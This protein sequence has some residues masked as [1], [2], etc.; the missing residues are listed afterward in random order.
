MSTVVVKRPA[1]R[2]APEIPE[3]EL[4]VEAPPEIPAQT[5]A[6]WQQLL[7]VLPMLGGT[8][9]MAMMFGRDGGAYSYVVGGIFGLSSL[10]ML[11]SSWANSSGAPKKSEMMAA[12][13]EYLRHLAALRRRVRDTAARQRAGLHYRHPD[14]T[15]L[16][17]TAGSHRVW[18]RR[19]LDEDFAVVRVGV[20]PQTL[21]TPLVAPLTRPLDELEPMTAGALRRF[22]DAHS[23]LPDLPVALS[24][25]GFAR[26]HVRAGA[27]ATGPGPVPPAT[28]PVPDGGEPAALVRAT[29]TQLAVFHAPDELL[30]A[31][32]T[33]PERRP[34]W[35]WVKW[36][37]HA[38]HPTRHDALG[39]VRLVT[40][41]A[42]EL[43]E[44]LDE[45]LVNRPRFRP[46]TIT[47]DGPHL[48]VVLDGGELTGAN[49]L[50]AEGGVD[51]LTVLDLQSR[52]PRLPDRVT[53]VL[54]VTAAQLISTTIDGAAEVGRPD[55]LDPADAEGIARRLAP[56]R[57]A[58]GARGGD[59]PAAADPGL[60][61]L[62]GIGDPENWAPDRGWTPRAH[63]DRLRVPIGVGPDG[64]TV[65]L[66]LKESAQDG[67]GPHGLLIG[68]IFALVAYGVATLAYGSGFLA[69]YVAGLPGDT[70]SLRAI[71]EDELEAHLATRTP[72]WAAAITGWS[73]SAREWCTQ[74][75][76]P[77][78]ASIP[79]STTS[80][81]H[82][83]PT[84]SSTTGRSPS[85]R[86]H[87]RTSSSS[88]SRPTG[89]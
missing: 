69:V 77:I 71:S 63:R 26:V 31:V 59:T 32:C 15:R 78:A 11:V 1:R 24:L 6:R 45:L 67:M 42:A 76:W 4:T 81:S 60:P 2:P 89:R 20:G 57:L 22:L 68:A 30:I 12:R 84:S 28:G 19:P 79:T 65:E 87:R 43:E 70:T 85:R 25:R 88:S 53:L 52:P 74:R 37:P 29:L 33:G 27:P 51:G 46:G 8:T 7:M 82:T 55:L 36:L 64:G 39:P 72:A 56:L 54:H 47:G 9:A 34:A 66:D 40:S 62:L 10:A 80:S 50:T 23:V 21:A 41:T 49:T 58:T 83:R 61:E 44:L 86:S 16:W 14:P 5:Q 35:E 18:E 17:S 48:V 73:C 75:C 38:R 13:R 3:G